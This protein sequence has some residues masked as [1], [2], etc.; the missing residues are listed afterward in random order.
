MALVL[1]GSVVRAH[2]VGVQLVQEPTVSA[3]AVQP[4]EQAPLPALLVP[5]YLAAWRVATG[6]WGVEASR[7]LQELLDSELVLPGPRQQLG[8]DRADRVVPA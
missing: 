2:V 5:L 8:A 4:T 1:V 3:A 7:V 6:G